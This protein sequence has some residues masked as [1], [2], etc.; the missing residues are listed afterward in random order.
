MSSMSNQTGGRKKRGN[1]LNANNSTTDDNNNNN[2]SN[3][4]KLNAPN[5]ND[6]NNNKNNNEE[7]LEFEDPYEDELS[8]EEEDELNV[9]M[10]KEANSDEEAALAGG[11]EAESNEEESKHREVWMPHKGMSAEEQL[12]YDSTAYLMLHRLKVEWPCLTFDII[13]DNLGHFRTKF[14]HQ[15]Y[16]ATGSQANRADKNKVSILKIT[17]LHKTKNDER[18]EENAEDSDSDPED[19]DDDPII[20]EKSFPHQGA[21]NRLKICPTLPNLLAT[22]SESK[23]VHIWN[24]SNHIGAL[25][26]PGA[27]TIPKNYKPLFT[28]DSALD[29]GYALAWS[30]L[31][32]GRLIT[33]DNSKNIYLWNPAGNQNT[34]T[35]DVQYKQPFIG[36]AN[37]VEDLCWSPSEDSVFASASSD[38]TIRMW[39]IRLD[40]KR[41]AAWIAAHRSDVN[42]ISWNQK[43]QHL[44]LSGSDDGSIKVWDLRN[45]KSNSHVALFNYH[46]KPIT[47][48]EWHSTEESIF[49]AASEDDQISIWD[50][51][52]ETDQEE[53]KQYSTGAKLTDEIPP[54]LFFV[55]QGQSNIKEIHWHKQIPSCLISTAADGLNIFK[56]ANLDESQA[57]PNGELPINNNNIPNNNTNNNTEMA[58]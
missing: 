21:V 44:L 23:R 5:T 45:F 31:V 15:L 11:E 57:V 51:S 30:N 8:Q 42:V 32:N 52:L 14:P 38:K 13:P 53:I 18:V 7:E 28:F 40:R 43:I 9:N 4:K 10:D 25:D 19:T 1:Q 12:D 17:D 47:S 37:S 58:S 22:M 20:E 2:K 35:W 24:I 34:P 55:H 41:S 54:Q 6:V 26:K 48:V 36:H 29:E 50:L 3:A 56:A 39:D 49:A 16:L 27:I 46:N 33:G